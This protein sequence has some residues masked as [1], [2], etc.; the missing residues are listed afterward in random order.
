MALSKSMLR[1]LVLLHG[2]S[3]STAENISLACAYRV[4]ARCFDRSNATAPFTFHVEQRI[5]THQEC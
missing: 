1:V 3:A 2:L 5:H 4:F